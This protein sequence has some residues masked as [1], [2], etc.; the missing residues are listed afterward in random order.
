[1]SNIRAVL[2][3]RSPLVLEEL[4]VR[5]RF[6]DPIDTYE[7]PADPL[8]RVT[9]AVERRLWSLSGEG[10]TRFQR[11]G[12]YEPKATLPK[13]VLTVFDVESASDRKKVIRLLHSEMARALYHSL[14]EIPSRPAEKVIRD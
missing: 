12:H 4:N 3:E 7:D 8:P 9:V 1:M 13:K 5:I 2:V 11:F 6:F 10:E 14:G